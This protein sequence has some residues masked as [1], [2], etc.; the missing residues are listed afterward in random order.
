MNSNP[1]AFNLNPDNYHSIEANQ[2]YLSVSQY[3]GFLK[4]EAEAMAKIDGK[5]GQ[6]KS[7]ALIFGSLLHS[8]NESK[9][10][11]DK[12]LFSNPDLLSSRGKTKGQ[13]KSTYLQVFDLIKRLEKDEL[14]MKALSGEKEKIFTAKMF[15]T[16]WKICIDSYEPE[17]GKFADLK[18]MAEIYGRYYN[19]ETQTYED[20]IRYYKYD[21]Q[22]VIYSEIEKIATGRKTNLNPLLVVITK[23]NPPDTAIFKGFL[24]NKDIFLDEVRQKVVR[25]NDLKLHLV[26]PKMCGSCAFCRSIKNTPIIEYEKFKGG[27]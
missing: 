7:E 23:Q 13:L 20:F 21:L 25:I 18:S 22:M 3:K 15:D 14:M 8:W 12:F 17:K 4:C 9:E 6:T 11:F 24:G 19:P 1:S 16:N 5:I 27:V 2:A 26:E 10:A